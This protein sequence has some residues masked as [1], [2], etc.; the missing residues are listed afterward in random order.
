MLIAYKI[1]T[2]DLNE[3]EGILLAEIRQPGVGWDEDF[4]SSAT[5]YLRGEEI[6]R[7]GIASPEADASEYGSSVWLIVPS[8]M[9]ATLRWGN[10]TPPIVPTP[11]HAKWETAMG[12][13]SYYMFEVGVV[14][15]DGPV[16]AFQRQN[17]F[18]EILKGGKVL[19]VEG[20]YGSFHGPTAL[21]GYA[22]RRAAWEG[23]LKPL[24]GCFTP[25]HFGGPRA[26]TV[27]AEL[28]KAVRP[29]TKTLRGLAAKIAAAYAEVAPPTMEGDEAE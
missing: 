14:I 28:W 20:T 24:L 21:E 27:A 3:L 12:H 11:A 5:L 8:E 16:G 29:P 15:F 17:L 25:P 13:Y 10:W 23:A 18:P 9:A 4:A 6:Y 22:A 19:A 1:E 2:V 7:G 26:T